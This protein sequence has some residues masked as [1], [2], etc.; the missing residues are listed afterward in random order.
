MEVPDIAR[1]IDAQLSL[2]DSCSWRRVSR[3]LHDS[4]APW[5]G[6]DV[7]RRCLAG[8]QAARRPRPPRRCVVDGCR[9]SP[10]VHVAWSGATDL[11]TPYAPYC[12]RHMDVE[13]L[14]FIAAFCVGPDLY[15][16]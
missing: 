14:P 16:A 4:C 5:T 9:R 8:L 6:R 13:L 10:I 15:P 12:E 3:A 2:S 7:R 1:A 11:V